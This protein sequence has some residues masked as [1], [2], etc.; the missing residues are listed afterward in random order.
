MMDESEPEPGAG[1]QRS[2]ESNILPWFTFVEAESHPAHSTHSVP[3]IGQA[4]Q[5]FLQENGKLF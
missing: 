1:D 5:A 2:C 3:E 4:D